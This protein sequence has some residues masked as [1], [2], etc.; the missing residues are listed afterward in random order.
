[1]RY[2]FIDFGA[3]FVY[4]TELGYPNIVGV[5]IGLKQTEDTIDKKSREEYREKITSP[6][7]TNSSST[8]RPL[9]STIYEGC[10]LRVLSHA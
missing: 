6:K 3:H 2:L 1:M 5:D 4:V 8:V 9:R 10:W 7:S